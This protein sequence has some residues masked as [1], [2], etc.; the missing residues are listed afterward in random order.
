MHIDAEPLRRH[1]AG[2]LDP[3]GAVEAEADGDGMDH[4][5]LDAVA[6][7]PA[8][9]EQ[10][11]QIGFTHLT[12]GHRDLG[13]GPRRARVAGRDIDHHAGDRG[14]GHFLGRVDDGAHGVAGRFHIDD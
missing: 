4:L 9:I 2:I 6:P 5:A 8:P 12:A 11:P 10:A 14:V 1:A 7:L 13:I 3:G